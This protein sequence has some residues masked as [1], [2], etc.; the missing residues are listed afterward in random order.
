MKHILIV[1]VLLLLPAALFTQTLRNIE[2]IAPFSEGLAAIRKGNQWGFMNEQGTLVID[3]RGDLHWNKDADPDNSDVT[4]IRY[5]MFRD[6]RCMITEKVEDGIPVYGFIDIHGNVVVEPK[7]LNVYPFKD[8]YTTGIFFDKV[9]KGENEFKLKI[10]EFKFFDVMVDTSGEIV[11]YFEKRDAIQ[12]TAR[13]YKL[14]VIGAKLLG[15][16]L[17]AVYMNGQGWE[18]RKMMTTN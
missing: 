17:V 10:Y 11:E 6:G 13:R 12:M 3:F 7:F 5:P 4:G 8:G 1:I 2:E 18:I 15:D 16:G 14:P 9:L